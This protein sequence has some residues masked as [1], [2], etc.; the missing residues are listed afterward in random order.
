LAQRDG[1]TI[2][3][4]AKAAG[5]NVETIRY[6]QRRKL[7]VEPRKPSGGQRRYPPAVLEQ[8]AF[9]R[10]AQALGFSLEEIGTLLKAAAGGNCAE[11]CG[12]AEAKLVVLDA[13]IAE[14]T[15]MRGSLRELVDASRTAQGRRP[16]PLLAAL[17]A[18]P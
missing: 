3:R 9:I 10:R 16:C 14:L 12:L 7:I 4:L 8:L 2:G 17:N 15:R 5:V 13:R 18:D 1:L 6:Y 11:A